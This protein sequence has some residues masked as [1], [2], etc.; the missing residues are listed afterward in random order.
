MNFSFSLSLSLSLSHL[1]IK[2]DKNKYQQAIV[3]EK[4]VHLQVQRS[5]KVSAYASNQRSCVSGNFLH[6]RWKV[7]FVIPHKFRSFE[8]FEPGAATHQSTF[9]CETLS[10]TTQCDPRFE[11]AGKSNRYS[12]S[13]SYGLNLLSDSW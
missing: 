2:I 9:P 1:K 5:H 6:S 11:R 8:S 13:R 10:G 7:C 12:T 4:Q 3:L